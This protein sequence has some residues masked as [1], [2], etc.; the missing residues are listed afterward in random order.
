VTSAQRRR[1]ELALLLAPALIFVIGVIAYP[2][3]LSVWYSLTDAS[4]G[5][6]GN[7]IGLAQYGFLA[8]DAGY[9]SALAHTAVYTGLSLVLKLGLGTLLALAL[10]AP[11]HG[12]RLVYVL[13]LLPLLFPVVMDSITWYFLLSTVGGGVNY[14][15][16]TLHL[17]ASPYPFLGSGTSA[18]I[19]LVAINVWHGTPLVAML[20][21]AAVGSISPDVVDSARLEGA[22][23]AALFFQLRLPAMIPAL[24]I[25]AFLS[26]LG[27]FGDYAIVHL[28]TAGGPAGSTHI[29]SSLA[30]TAA[31]RAGD[32]ATGIAIAL[33]VVPVY[34]AGLAAVVWV[35]FRR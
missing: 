31:L 29:I 22:G 27:T 25:A 30:F 17:S 33:S 2:F 8:R 20:A 28:V 24:S 26:L 23:A 9:W 10:A 4:I 16:V 19:S 35:L 12:R 21:L 15:L 13:L 7:F 34:L 6:T 14:V 5:E 3:A 1:L 32:L 18:M 11:F